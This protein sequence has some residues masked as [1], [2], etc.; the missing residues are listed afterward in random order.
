MRS[1]RSAR[2]RGRFAP[3]ASTANQ[4]PKSVSFARGVWSPCHAP[5]AAVIAQRLASPR[6]SERR[7]GPCQPWAWQAFSSRFARFRASAKRHTER[8]V[9]TNR[10]RLV[11][12]PTDACF[13][14]AS[15]RVP[16]APPPLSRNRP[17]HASGAKLTRRSQIWR[18]V[19]VG[20]MA[21]YTIGVEV[22]CSDGVCGDLRRVVIDPVARVLTHLVVEPKH[23][24]H[25]NR[26]RQR[27]CCRRRPT[28]SHTR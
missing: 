4:P 1:R 26:R 5:R 8:L 9:W 13:T 20:G 27:R 15:E 21:Q 28:Q 6:P 12:H 10:E 24:G 3:A 16:L 7:A 17:N 23:R 14:F 18:S 19:S 22:T 2:T 25:S 11:R